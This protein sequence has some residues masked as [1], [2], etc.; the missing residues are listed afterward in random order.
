PE[1]GSEAG[2]AASAEGEGLAL[3]QPGHYA[4]KRELARGGQ[5]VVYVAHD[6][7]MGREIAFKQL[8]PGGP[9]DAEQRFL[10]E[11]RVAG[12]LEHPGV[13]PVYELGRR[14]DGS[15]Y[16][17]MR[18]VR[19]HSLAV[20]L[21]EAKGRTRLK[22]LSSYVQLCQTVAYAHERGVIHRDVK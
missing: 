15:L 19:G 3:E 20:A 9:K 8:L 1:A 12:Q 21:K 22:L 6:A 2:P 10:T 7:H 5:A 13:V 14:A 18:L 4:L 17:A 11:A 16:C